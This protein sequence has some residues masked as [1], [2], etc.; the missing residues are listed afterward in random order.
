MN[1][2]LPSP[3]QATGSVAG[4]KVFNKQNFSPE[5][6]QLFQ[7]MFE[8][9]SP[10]SYTS[11]LASGDQSLFNEMEAPAMNQFNALQGN[12]ASRFSFGGGPGSLSS[13]NSSG[14]QNTMTAAN[15]NFSQQLQSQRQALQRQA[16][17]DLMSMSSDILGQR[18]QEQFLVRPEEKRSFM[19][20]LLGGLF[21]I[22]GS[23]IGG[24]FGGPSGALLGG[25]IGSGIF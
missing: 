21:P 17:Q 5:Q 24:A 2:G 1:T 4:H 18:P 11:R 20:R 7:R 3:T 10:Q 15:Q 23:G 12:V 16:I 13:R 9:V 14:F 19:E 6:M 8:Q 22:A 25:K